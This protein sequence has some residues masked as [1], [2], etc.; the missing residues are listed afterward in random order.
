M[1]HRGEVSAG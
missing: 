1:L